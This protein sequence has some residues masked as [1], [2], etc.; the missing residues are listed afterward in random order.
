MA[1]YKHVAFKDAE[2]FCVKVFQGYGFTEEE[3]RKITDVLLSADLY[4]IESHG[5]QRLIRYHHEITDGMVKTDAKPEIVKETP[6]SAVIE[7]NDA[8]GQLLGIDAMNLAIEKAKK[9]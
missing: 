6:L 5:I 3:S 8:M 2:N 4:G 9:S 1:D 7:G